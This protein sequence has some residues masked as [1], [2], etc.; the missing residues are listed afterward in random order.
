MQPTTATIEW[1]WDGGDKLRGWTERIRSWYD[2]VIRITWLMHRLHRATDTVKFGS[3]L[4]RSDSNERI[5]WK[6]ITGVILKFG[7][8]AEI[9]PMSSGQVPA[10]RS[11]TQLI[12]ISISN[13][14]F[15]IFRPA[16]DKGLRIAGLHVFNG[17]HIDREHSST[18]GDARQGQRERAKARKKMS[19]IFH[20][21]GSIAVARPGKGTFLFRPSA[22]CHGASGQ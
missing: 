9:W 18:L 7:W 8:N 2:H 12:R 5:A 4:A 16:F 11:T 17:G 22:Q 14:S 20:P 21:T 13:D 19:S 15:R 3:E 1:H 6:A 10:A